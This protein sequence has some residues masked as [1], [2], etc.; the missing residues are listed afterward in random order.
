MGRV[1]QESFAGHH[2][3]QYS[4]TPLFAKF[5][6]KPTLL[7]HPAD[8]AFRNMGVQIIDNKNPVPSRVCGDSFDDMSHEIILLAGK[9]Q[10]GSDYFA[11]GD[12]KVDREALSAVANV[13]ILMPFDFARFHRQVR[14]FTLQCLERCLIGADNVRPLHMKFR[15]L[16]VNIA[17]RLCLLLE[18]FLVADARRQPIAVKVRF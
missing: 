3:L 18:N 16:L 6:R 11:G 7:R 8:K 4:V 15:R 13:F 10:R 14:R 5:F 9:I 17:Y 2:G 1:A 12:L